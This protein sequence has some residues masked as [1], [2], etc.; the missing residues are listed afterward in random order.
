V[1]L[2][3][4]AET[5]TTKWELIQAYGIWI[6]AGIMFFAMGMRGGGGC[7]GMGHL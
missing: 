7:C 1:E 6:V 2:E 3:V 4:R 5:H